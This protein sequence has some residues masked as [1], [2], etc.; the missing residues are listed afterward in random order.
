MS[1]Q[2]LLWQ[3]SSPNQPVSF[4]FL[5]RMHFS[6]LRTFSVIW[7]PMLTLT[8]LWTLQ[9]KVSFVWKNK[10]FVEQ[11]INI[12]ISEKIHYAVFAMQ[13]FMELWI[14]S[15]RYCH[16]GMIYCHWWQNMFKLWL[17][18]ILSMFNISSSIYI[19]FLIFIFIYFQWRQTHPR[20]RLRRERQ[21]LVWDL[22]SQHLLKLPSASRAPPLQAP[23][24][25]LTSQSTSGT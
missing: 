12:N 19:Y 2:H 5:S 20:R 13:L 14:G 3:G 18:L 22:T 16:C 6:S 24:P 21:L 8:C 25:P 17:K 10:F 11:K 23:L 7:L 15:T 9:L 1:E 4:P